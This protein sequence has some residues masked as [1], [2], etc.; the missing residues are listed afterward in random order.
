MKG[1]LSFQKA[2]LQLGTAT[3]TPRTVSSQRAVDTASDVD[4]PPRYLLDLSLETGGPENTIGNSFDFEPAAKAGR[5]EKAQ[6]RQTAGAKATG[7][8]KC[9]Q[10]C[11]AQLLGVKVSQIQ[12]H[13]LYSDGRLTGKQMENGS[14]ERNVSYE[15][16]RWSA[17]VLRNYI[18]IFFFFLL[19]LTLREETVLS[20]RHGC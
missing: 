1:Q 18:Q 15:S 16:S 3:I 6:G 20:C 14:E 12:E 10:S 17:M 7:D 4:K 11:L 8:G 2:D 5:K 9:I 19:R 13:H